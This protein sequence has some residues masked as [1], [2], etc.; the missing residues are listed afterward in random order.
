MRLKRSSAFK[1]KL[2]PRA[3][4]KICKAIFLF[5]RKTVI[6]IERIKKVLSQTLMLSRKLFFRSSEKLFTEK[7]KEKK[8]MF[9]FIS[10]FLSGF[11]VLCD[12]QQHSFW[13]ANE[14][15]AGRLRNAGK[16]IK[17]SAEHFSFSQYIFLLRFRAFFASTC[18][19]KT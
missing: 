4:R 18:E 19:R 7:S 14:R 6:E 8:K 9:K 16:F 12:K 2:S 3:K 10:C 17:I 5:P 1:W 13:F 11:K 15:Q